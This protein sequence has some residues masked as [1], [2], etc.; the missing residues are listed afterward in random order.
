M[1]RIY[2]AS[3]TKHAVQWRMLR[4]LGYNVVSTWIDEAGP[5][6]TT[7]RADLWLRCIAEAS[8]C[9][10]LI[11]YREDGETL[12]GAYIEMG[13]ALAHNIQVMFVGFKEPTFSFLDHP[14]V[15][16]HQTVGEAL[17]GVPA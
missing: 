17:F 8:T 12:K 6:E 1:T 13:A 14:L 15:T 2:V 7:D 4:Q 10:L 11:L 16:C 3:K 5:G 9:D